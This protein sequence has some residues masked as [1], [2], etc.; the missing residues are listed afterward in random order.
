MAKYNKKKTYKKTYKKK[1]LPISLDRR[2]A[3]I[4]RSVFNKNTETKHVITTATDGVEIYHN[5]FQIVNSNPLRSS[6][7]TGDDPL[8]S[9]IGD[10]INVRGLSFKMMLELNERYSDVTFRVMLIRSAKGDTP[11]RA[12]LFKGMSGNK[13]LDAIDVERYKIIAQ[14]YLKIKAPNDG[15]RDTTSEYGPGSGIMTNAVN[16]EHRFKTR[17]TRIVKMWIPGKAFGRNGLVKYENATQQQQ[18][19][20]HNLIVYA[21]SNYSTLQDVYYV[22]RINDCVTQLYFKDA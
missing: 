15:L 20:D 17:A 12:T 18:F 3:T 9:R 22:G 16:P 5:S 4:A 6:Q 19:F 2:I 10:E 21:Y 14:K 13:M 8:T 7:G 1:K 11:T